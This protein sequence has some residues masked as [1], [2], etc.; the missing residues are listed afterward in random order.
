MLRRCLFLLALVSALA[1]P[2]RAQP[3]SERVT[4]A[5]AQPLFIAALTDLYMGDPAR[6]A[7][8]LGDVLVA[9]PDDPVVLDALAEAYLAQGLTA[10]ALYHAELAASLAPD[11]A[12][13][14]HRLADAYEASGDATQAQLARDAARRLAPETDPPST[15]SPVGPVASPPAAP[16]ARTPDTDLPGMAA[17]RAGRY[18]EAAEALLDVVDRDPRQI[19]AWPLVLDALART[20]DS[21][22][23]DTAD[24][25]LLLYPTVPSVLVPAAEVFR[26]AGRMDDAH[27][28]AHAALRAL[29]AGPDDLSLRQRADALLSSL[30]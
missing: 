3:G 20:S 23:G 8:R 5:E 16:G 18:A 6:A 12:S 22:A 9:Y 17:Y 10:E 1:T 21:R 4:Q 13:I 27:D 7:T 2:I 24:L 19:E 29:D 25:A 14:Q 15:E 28:A 11:D 30:R 26:A